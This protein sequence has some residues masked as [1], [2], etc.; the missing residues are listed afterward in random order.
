MSKSIPTLILLCLSCTLAQRVAAQDRSIIYLSDM[1]ESQSGNIHGGLGKDRP[2][3]ASELR[4]GNVLYSKGLVTHPEGNGSRAFVEYDLGGRFR[5]FFAT[6]GSAQGPSAPGMGRM[7]YYILVDGQQV[8]AG[9]IPN[10]PAVVQINV[11]L[12]GAN[13]LRLEADDGGDGNNSDHAAWG[14]ARIEKRESTT[15]LSDMNEIRNGNLHGGLGKDHPYW[16][17]DIIIGSSRFE[18]GIVTHPPAENDRRAFV[19]YDLKGYFTTFHA[20]LGSAS[21]DGNSGSGTMNYYIIVDGREVE[22]GPFPI[23]PTVKE[24]SVSVRNA[25]SLKLE[26][27]NGGNGN[28]SDHAAWGNARLVRSF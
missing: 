28:N 3:W 25:R 14:D 2:Y 8:A 27:D 20:T 24:I 11:S 13:I 22:R 19:T 17:G 9:P 10:Y 4:I 5:A 15:F 12:E 6:V 1:N 23:P 7:N 18:K 16:G 21:Q 26:V